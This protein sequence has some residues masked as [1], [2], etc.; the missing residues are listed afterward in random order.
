MKRKFIPHL[1]ILVFVLSI[2]IY[3]V[4]AQTATAIVYYTGAQSLGCCTVCNEDYWCIND[5]EVG[6]CGTGVTCDSRAF[7]DPVPW[8]ILL[9][10]LLLIIGRPVVN[11]F[12]DAADVLLVGE[13]FGCDHGLADAR[14][15][16]RLRPARG[17][18]D[19]DHASVGHRDVVPHARRGGNQVQLVFALEALMDDLHVEQSQE[20]TAKAEAQSDGT[21]RLEE[22]G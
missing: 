2:G 7:F 18:I 14:N 3:R 5:N 17:V 20:S 21:L 4:S 19:V 15:A 12:E 9:L 22:E 6:A 16:L 8:G 13:D 11:E 1:F 10:I